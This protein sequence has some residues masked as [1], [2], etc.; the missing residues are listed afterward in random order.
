MLESLRRAWRLPDLR[1]RI[2][3]TLAM[4]FVLRVGTHVPVP[5]IDASV[6][7]KLFKEG[8][9]FGLLD[10]FSGGALRT[11]SVFAMSVTPYINASIIFQL[12]TLVIPRLEELA[13][14]GEEGRKKITQYTRYLTVVLAL[15]QAYGMTVGLRSAVINPTWGS[16]TVIAL[17][18]TAGTAF[19]MWLGEQITEKGIG[20]GISLLIFAGIVARLPAGAGSIGTYLRG[21]RIN[22]FNLALLA[23][24][25]ALA[26]A[27]VVWVNEG[28]RRLP[29]QYPKR[30]VGRRMYGGQSAHIPLRVNHAGVIPII[31]ASSLLTFPLTLSTFINRPWAVNFANWFR[32]DRPLYLSTYA[33]LVVFFTYFYT[34]IVFNPNDVANNIKKYGGF[35][36]G[37]RPG[38]PTA[39]Y[40]TRVMNRVTLA[41]SLFLAVIAVMPYMMGAFTNIPGLYFGGTALLIVVGVALETMKQIEAH[42]VMRQYQGFL[43]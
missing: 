2:L 31:F 43:R 35:I 21:G 12:L 33:I 30:V 23:A 36:P 14:E 9:L 19:L 29:V 34:A 27:A 40:L 24:V 8:T 20:N 6:I 42:L 5:G 1:R 18:L 22:W 32:M 7:Q 38:K 11:F 26:I 37:L 13:K 17:S 39:D 41:G 4:F 16:F 3:F 15:I 28:Q 25:G 10:L